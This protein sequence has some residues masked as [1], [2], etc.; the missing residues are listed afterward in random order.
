MSGATLE[1]LE[2][3]YRRRFAECVR[4]AAAVTG[5][6]GRGADAVHDGFARAIA[7]RA[8]FRGD[9]PLEAWVWRI[10]L[11]AARAARPRA[12]A[13]NVNTGKIPATDDRDYHD[14]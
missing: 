1:A 13:N 9:G 10:V 11:N 2:L 5:D 14:P 7:A 4:V 12:A 6:E 8:Q 3:L